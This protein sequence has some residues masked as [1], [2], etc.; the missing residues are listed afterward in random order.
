MKY[1]GQMLLLM[2]S[3]VVTTQAVPPVLNYAGQVAVNGEA[4]DG[5]GLFKFALVN[6]NGST[7]YWSN[8]GTSVNGSQ[9]QASVSVPVIGGLY[10]ILLGNTAQQG[11]AA[12]D[13]AVFAQHTDAKLR[14]WFSDGVNGF[15]QLSPDRPFASVPY[16]FNSKSADTANTAMAVQAGA[17]TKQMLN[18]D[19]LTDINA[20]IGMNRLATEVTEKLNQEKTTTNNYNAPSVGS[21]LAVPYGSDAPAGY[22]LYQQGT[23]NELVWEEKAPVNK[24][25]AAYDGVEVLSGKIYFVGD[26]NDTG[27]NNTIERYDPETNLWETLS[28][29]NEARA[30][31]AS[32]V[33]D[34]KIYAIGGIGL[35]S[36]EVY[37]PDLDSWTFATPLPRVVARG[38]AVTFENK[39]YLFG[40]HNENGTDLNQVLVFDNSNNQWSQVSTMPSA[41]TSFKA[42]TFNERIWL[43]GGSN[44]M[45]NS[46]NTIAR[47]YVRSY[48]VGNNTWHSES[49]LPQARMW[50]SA[51]SLNSSLIVA[52]GASG[53][54]AFKDIFGYDPNKKTW[55][56]IGHLSDNSYAAGSVVFGSSLYLIS[57]LADNDINAQQNK[58]FVTNLFEDVYDLYRKDGDTPVGTPVVQSEYADG[59]VT[60]SKMADGAIT[61]NKLN[62]QILKY[63]KPEITAQPQAQ[64]V[65]ADSNASFSV[66]AE[67]KYLTY[68]WK[69]DGVDLAGETNATLIITDANATLHYGNY[70]VAVNNDFGSDE[71]NVTT[72]IVVNDINAI[73]GLVGWWKFDE[74]NGTI[75]NDSSGYERHANMLGFDSNQSYW[76]SGKIGGSLTFDGVNDYAEVQGFY[77]INGHNPRTI[78]A[79]IKTDSNNS[80]I[81]GWGRSSSS[82]EWK[83]SIYN[84]N[85]RTSVW[86][87]W[88]Y[89]SNAANVNDW[90][91][92]ASIL[93]SEASVSSQIMHYF[94]GNLEILEIQELSIITGED[95]TVKIGSSMSAG[96]KMNGSIDDLRL[97]DRALSAAEVQALYNLG[98]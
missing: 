68:Q 72:F 47:N 25:R 35:S 16:A 6:A 71:S 82:K 21:L 12:I 37:D 59:S 94:N 30:G 31:V 93:P 76:T 62:E 55:N 41:L 23:P 49:S 1:I 3:M 60:G 95:Y 40:G 96:G 39:I 57:G 64:T 28:S 20:T 97:Y 24:A 84:G 73:S 33:L 98:Q 13:P 75:A 69:K 81:M 4:Y 67:G 66:S 87:G 78:S 10:S 45:G 9:P 58:V 65:Y 51:W 48:D 38:A 22:S 79:W 92:I 8:D 36:V 34:G 29:A 90:V 85:F 44:N 32:T 86:S 53:N 54:N 83:L 77:G 43:I 50:I 11:M 46:S 7:T 19:V 17:I 15:Q 91:Y 2:L 63:L 52:G 26:Y 18:S 27:K 70:S 89:G 42:I 5:N 74:T 80:N 56:S 88:V 61:T 14:V